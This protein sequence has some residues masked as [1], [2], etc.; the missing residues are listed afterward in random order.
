VNT[1]LELTGSTEFSIPDLV[2]YAGEGALRI[3]HFQRS[4]VWSASDVRQLF[5]SIY[6]GFP[7][8]TFLL[9]RRDAQAED[10]SFGPISFHAP[11]RTDAL[12]VV[13]GQQRITSLFGVLTP[14]WINVDPRFEV[15][16]DLATRRFVNLKSGV[17]PT[18]AIPLREALETKRLAA[19]TRQHSDYLEVDD[20]DLADT[21]VG[22]IRDYRISAYVVAEDD[23]ALLREV[24][25]RVN[26]AGKPITR[27]QVF[28]ALFASD[29]TPGS[30]AVV[31]KELGRLGFGALEENRVVQSLL[32]IRG[33]DVQ[34]D[35]RD[36]FS[37][38]DD[39]FDW[40][41]RTEEALARGF[42]FLRNEGVPHIALMPYS[43]PLPVLAAFFH[44]HQEP[45]TWIQHLLA[46][47][48][49]RGWIYG[50]SAQTAT[51]RRAVRAVNPKR[52]KPDEAP[53]EYEAV[54]TLLQYVPER[55]IP[56]IAL[57]G[58]RTDA[59][60]SRL[61]LL[62][63]A[64]LHPLRP[65]G[66]EIDVAEEFE[67]YGPAAATELVRGSR[68]NAA[69][70]SLWPVDGPP[71]TG[72]EDNRVLR[73]HAIDE[74][75]ADRY[76]QGDI[77]GFIERRRSTLQSLMEAFVNNHVEPKGVVRPPLDELIV[78]DA[79]VSS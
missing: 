17:A 55:P 34:R 79:G 59:A 47:W 42:R 25:D 5:D 45:S 27:A 20:Y 63:L 4:F 50:D 22:V 28:H 36:E 40:Y 11:Y 73:S 66:T 13:D 19:W 31:V 24:F 65:D 57:D 21:L 46:R 69:S 52:L 68:A 72:E 26:S 49:W 54:R 43:L 61:I 75:A 60:P 62:A 2:K 30:P 6:R 14:D 7:I 53:T 9:W 39:P 51:L 18:R 67:K 10:I 71:L 58:F 1:T 3:P 16:F 35:F 12:W 37:N 29:T 48:L 8:G 41:D 76:R 77:Q 44:L 15:Y 23:E 33:G 74:Y 78:A 32:A 56:T 38:G 70:R 64:S